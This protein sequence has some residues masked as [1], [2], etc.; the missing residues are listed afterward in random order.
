MAHPTGADQASAYGRYRTERM[1]SL[2]LPWAVGVLHFAPLPA[3]AFC[4]AV[5]MDALSVVWFEG[6]KGVRRGP[7]GCLAKVRKSEWSH[8]RHAT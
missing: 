6:I 5:T 3:H 7:A 4:A 1:S 8:W 2:D